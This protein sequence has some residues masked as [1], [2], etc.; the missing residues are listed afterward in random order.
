MDKGR[1]PVATILVQQGTL[2][3][4]DYLVVGEQVGKVR[5]MTDHTGK[6]LKEAGPSSAVE[7]IGLEGTPQ[8]GDQFNRVESL[9]TARDIAEH[10]IEQAKVEENVPKQKMGLE[11]LMKRMRNEEV[12]ELRALF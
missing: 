4:G 7:I 2:R 11:E 10:R 5:A 3:K 8:A 12:P 9:D 1:G 6:Q